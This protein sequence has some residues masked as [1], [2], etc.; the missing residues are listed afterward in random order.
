MFAVYFASDR[1]SS[2]KS[3]VTLAFSRK[4]KD[5]GYSLSLYKTGPDFIDPVILSKALNSEVQVKNLDPFLIPDKFLKEWFF[6]EISPEFDSAVNAGLNFNA[7]ESKKAFIAESAMGLYD[8]NSFAVAKKFKFPVVL[9][10]DCKKISST[11]ASLIYGL[12]NYKK[13]INVCGVILNNIS[14][15]R[16]Y[17]IIRDEIKENISGVE[18]F[19]Y[20]KNDENI[21]S[22]KERHLGLIVPEGEGG[23]KTG[24]RHKDAGV[25]GGE[26]RKEIKIDGFEKT[27]V[28]IKDAVF[29]NV[30]FKFMINILEK[31]SEDFIM[32]I[33]GKKPEYKKKTYKKYAVKNNV[34]SENDN[35]GGGK[36]NKGSAGCNGISNKID[37]KASK[38]KIAVAFDEAFFFY[39]NF[40]FE[41]LKSFGAE[42]VFFSPLKDKLLPSG[43]KAVY[44]GGGYPE[45]YA[46]ALESNRSIKKE[47]YE[48]HKNNGIIYGECGGLMYLC[49]KISYKKKSYGACGIFPF[50]ASMDK[51]GLSLGYRRVR[52]K[53]NTFLGEAG[54]TVNG[55]EFHYS[56]LLPSAAPSGVT[57]IVSVQAY[58][59]EPKK[60]FRGDANK[61]AVKTVTEYESLS[62]PGIW[63]Q[64]GYNIL[65][66][67]GSYVHLS[68]YSNKI[69]AESFVK[70]AKNL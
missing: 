11:M 55:H 5:E 39:Y 28:N 4:L 23:Y 37:K 15:E 47:I 62:A 40:N 58:S 8:G 70:S 69:A 51:G 18:V 56:K 24:S 30:D 46:A 20:I 63:K 7:G 54:L 68:F 43:I 38:I 32:L 33:Y 31:N 61:T 27:V 21:F 60:P 52:L 34:G 53:E 26:T 25:S 35:S 22:I 36:D 17:E 19:G 9:I 50:E 6:K 1:S 65:N 3:T 44:I 16:H 66:T 12:K 41:I 29:K 48:F 49:E 10:M 13:G 14:S 64:E 59:N 67:I 45:I 42:I 57:P 2:G